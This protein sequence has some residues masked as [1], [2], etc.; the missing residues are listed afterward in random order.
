MA[1]IR[2]LYR[3][4][5]LCP[6]GTAVKAVSLPAQESYVRRLINVFWLSSNE[7]RQLEA[8]TEPAPRD[9]SVL[10]WTHFRNLFTEVS[11]CPA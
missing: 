3:P 9:R 11:S 6:D 4:S 10:P 5:L 8:G 7:T 1:I 2:A